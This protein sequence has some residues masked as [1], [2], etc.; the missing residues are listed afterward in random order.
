M[1]KQPFENNLA[2]SMATPELKSEQI[3]LVVLMHCQNAGFIS[4]EDPETNSPRYE[5][6]LEV[7]E[8]NLLSLNLLDQI[9]L[10]VSKQLFPLDVK[11]EIDGKAIS[12]VKDIAKRVMATTVLY[13]SPNCVETTSNSKQKLDM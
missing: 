1:E 6:L 8:L 9:I 5:W 13:P 12:I 10:D 3:R 7:L 4:K 11:T 2:N